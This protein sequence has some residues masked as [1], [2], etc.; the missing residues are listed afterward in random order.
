M[1]II[2]VILERLRDRVKILRNQIAW[3][4]DDFEA[5]DAKRKER[6]A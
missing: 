4:G 5:A 1:N 6:K 2:V 3:L